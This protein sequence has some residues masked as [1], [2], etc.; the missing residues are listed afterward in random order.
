MNA[1]LILVPSN[2]SLAG[3]LESI[4]GWDVEYHDETAVLFRRS[5]N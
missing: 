5:I 1:Q 2:S 4:P 3:A